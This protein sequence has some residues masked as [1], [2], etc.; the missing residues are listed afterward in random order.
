M[1]TA[2]LREWHGFEITEDDM[3]GVLDAHE[4]K[5]DAQA[6]LDSFTLAD[7]QKACENAEGGVY[8]LAAAVLSGVEDVL[9]ARG[10]IQGAK[11]F[12]GVMPT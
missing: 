1:K 9:L 3:R 4:V 7:L 8:E 5:Q 11:R 2:D 12:R 10:V 6:I